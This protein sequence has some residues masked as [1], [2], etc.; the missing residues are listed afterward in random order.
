MKCLAATAI[1]ILVVLTGP[2]FGQSSPT[3][4]TQKAAKDPD[5]VVCR[6]EEVT[7]SLLA[8]KRECHTNAEWQ[9]M[10]RQQRADLS[11]AQRNGR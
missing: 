3:A 11:Q 2:A 4:A 5:K 6:T 9:D 7:G 1:P 8:T 10:E